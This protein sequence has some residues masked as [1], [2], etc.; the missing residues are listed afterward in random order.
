ME[1][2]KFTVYFMG[3]ESEDEIPQGDEERRKWALSRKATLELTQ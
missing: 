3:F 1:A 2:G